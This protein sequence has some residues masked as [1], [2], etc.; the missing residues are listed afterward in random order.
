[1]TYKLNTNRN[2][3]PDPEYDSNT[4]TEGSRTSVNTT[5]KGTKTATCSWPD[6][7]QQEF[8]SSYGMDP[9]TNHRG[10]GY[11]ITFM[12]LLRPRAY[13]AMP[14]ITVAHW[15]TAV[16]KT[17]IYFSEV[18]LLS[19]TAPSDTMQAGQCHLAFPTS[20]DHSVW[21]LGNQDQLHFLLS[22]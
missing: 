20:Y 12:T 8:V 15:L 18:N 16:W 19:F 13:L 7:Q 4:H 6:V 10:I 2:L 1:M 9:S 22:P 14:V 3:I 5:L 11:S 17:V 21:C